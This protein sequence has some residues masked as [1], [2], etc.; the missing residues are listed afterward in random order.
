LN[1]ENGRTDLFDSEK[2]GVGSRQDQEPL[3]FSTVAGKN[4]VEVTGSVLQYSLMSDCEIISIARISAMYR[5][6][7]DAQ[8]F[9]HFLN[10]GHDPLFKLG[11]IFKRMLSRFNSAYIP[12]QNISLDEGMIP[13]RGNLSFR[14]YSPDKPVK[15]GD[16]FVEQFQ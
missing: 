10:P 2:W 16:G 1:N 8:V 3:T 14:V 12:H 13:W 5:F 4:G 7:S 6:I 15:Y 9:C 11:P